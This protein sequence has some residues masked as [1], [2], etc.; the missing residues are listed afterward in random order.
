MLHV[1][2]EKELAEGIEREKAKNRSMTAEHLERTV[3][4]MMREIDT[5]MK[6]LSALVVEARRTADINSQL[7][8]LNKQRYMERDLLQRE[9]EAQT[10]KISKNDQ[11]IRKLVEELK[12]QDQ[13]LSTTGAVQ[14]IP[15]EPDE[16]LVPQVYS[17]ASSPSAPDRAAEFQRFV[18]N[19]IEV[20]CRGVVG[21]LRVIDPTH[22]AD[23]QSFHDVFTSFD[24]HKK[25]LRFLMSKL[26]NLTFDPARATAGPDVG[27][28]DIEGIDA[29]VAEKRIVEP[30]KKA[31]LDFAEPVAPDEFPDLIAT[32]FF[33]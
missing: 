5:E 26:G 15:E 8:T 10:R 30:Q 27:Y 3:I 33:H 31:L 9:S 2:H 21:I 1:K 17:S 13:G 19:G 11:K 32:H 24:G 12:L 7:V 23:Y 22:A 6:K 14:A 29:D 28:A 20:L 16:R 4:E 25:E 18:E